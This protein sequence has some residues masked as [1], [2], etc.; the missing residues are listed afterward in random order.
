MSR[1]VR[2]LRVS[3]FPPPS[4]D[5]CYFTSLKDDLVFGILYS[6]YLGY[7]YEVM[8]SYFHIC[9]YLYEIGCQRIGMV[10]SG[11][12]FSELHLAKI[13]LKN[14]VYLRIFHL[15][16][17]FS[18]DTIDLILSKWKHS[19]RGLSFRGTMLTTEELLRLLTPITNETVD[20]DAVQE[21]LRQQRQ[22][23]IPNLISLD[24]SKDSL[25]KASLINDL[26]VSF[27]R[28]YHKLR[29]L[30]L[31]GTDIL[32]VSIKFLS[33]HMKQL[34]YLNISYCRHLS[35]RCSSYLKEMSVKSLNISGCPDLSSESLRVLLANR[36]SVCLFY[37]ILF[38]SS[39]AWFS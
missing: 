3:V 21:Q 15:D 10:S 12:S 6:G 33:E 14:I 9:K 30:S 26:G 31:A 29:W 2:M 18:N 5:E 13:P 7:G 28:N 32:N 38:Y 19:L 37:F 8:S 22:Q 20:Y 1:F 24:L 36:R 35:D 25:S 39:F 16:R 34:S 27:L 4:T 23:Y 17:P 11:H